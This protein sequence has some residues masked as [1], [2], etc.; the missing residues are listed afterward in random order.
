MVSY[1]RHLF[2]VWTSDFNYYYCQRRSERSEWDGDAWRRQACE[3]SEPVSARLSK[4]IQ[5]CL[6]FLGT[7]FAPMKKPRP[8]EDRGRGGLICGGIG[9]TC[10][11]GI[12]GWERARQ[13]KRA[14]S[15]AAAECLAAVIGAP[16]AAWR[17]NTAS[18]AR[19][20]RVAGWGSPP[21]GGAG[22]GMTLQDSACLDQ[23]HPLSGPERRAET[24]ALERG[25][26]S[27]RE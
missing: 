11:P 2:N 25:R 18:L 6:F 13:T 15:G 21:S 20:W 26:T 24:D 16:G 4:Q 10:V 1:Q 19:S 9:C 8:P 5:M 3:R 22:W 14:G 17:E 7:I 12:R 23:L 27:G